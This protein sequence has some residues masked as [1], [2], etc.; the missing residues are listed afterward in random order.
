MIH[1]DRHHE[2][3]YVLCVYQFSVED[4]LK[5]SARVHLYKR[6]PKRTLHIS[7]LSCLMV[8]E[9]PDTCAMLVCLA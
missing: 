2:T 9:L 1:A 3:A 8:D 6:I 5:I 7:F 4:R